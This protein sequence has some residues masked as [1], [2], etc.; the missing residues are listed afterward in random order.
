MR[1]ILKINNVGDYCA[2]IGYPVLHPLI[3]V[4]DYA[5][6]SPIRHS[7]NNYGVYGL[8]L[9]DDDIP[10]DL[11]YGYGNYDY[12]QGTLLCVAPGQIGGK[13]DNGETAAIQGMALLFHP[14]FLHGT[15]LEQAIREYSF[16][17]YHISEALHMNAEEHNT[18][19]S[20]MRQM[21]AELTGPHDMFQDAILLGYLE[22]LL[23]YCR[24]FFERQFQT[25]RQEETDLLKRF[26]RVLY[27]YFD[28]G[29]QQTFGL[30][31]V[32][33]CAERLCLTANYFSNRVR[34][35]TGEPAGDYIR[36]Y[37][38]QQAK[39]HLA[40]GTGVAQAAYNLGFEYPQHFSRMFKK[41]TGQTPKEYLAALH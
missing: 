31:T 36:R 18:L 17:D 9:R 3:C 6:V 26:N 16:F 12:G 7:L 40:S 35:L 27:D 1:N 32:H 38:I 37:I 14:D 41:N 10:I 28:T 30:P 29:R 5:R 8:F 25:R 39:N 4:I 34:E 24:R 19:V 33:Y 22:T 20:L 15:H 21:A 13:E 23:N 2:Y 11:T